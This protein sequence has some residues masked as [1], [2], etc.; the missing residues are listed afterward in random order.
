M[1]KE[2]LIVIWLELLDCLILHILF[3]AKLCNIAYF[4]VLTFFDDIIIIVNIDVTSGYQ[5]F[6]FRSVDEIAR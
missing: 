3:P 1:G 4:A 2:I 6:Y 5:K